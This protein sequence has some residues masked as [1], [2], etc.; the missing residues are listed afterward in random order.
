MRALQIS[1]PGQIAVVQKPNPRPGRD[2]LLLATQAAGL[3]QTDIELANGSM[4]YIREGRA[5]LPLTPGHE[6]VARVVGKGED[7]AGFEVGNLVVG[8]CSIG[9]GHCARCLSGNYHQ[10][11]DRHETGVLNLDGAMSG[12]FIFPARAAHRLI[13]DTPIEDAV[14]A[15]PA[16]VALRA[17]LRANW[18]GGESVLVV[19]AGT[20]GWL[21]AAIVMDLHGITVAVA[22][23]EAT[24]RVRA[25][26]L[27]CREGAPDEQF[28]I[29]FEASGNTAAVQHALEA[30][31]PSGRVIAVG[32]TGHHS[33][34]VDIDR[35]VVRDQ[36]VTGSLGSPGV[37]TQTLTML[38]KGRLRPSSLVTGRYSL[39]RAPDAYAALAAS[40]PGTGKLL[41]VP[42]EEDRL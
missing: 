25:I 13:P 21:I 10:C 26:E 38:G 20:I 14:F 33:H 34:P 23:P 32:L 8:E 19:G 42:S 17:V 37:W 1:G 29:V 4:V 5:H 18:Q 15:E 41:I 35:I 28:D 11:P 24:R 6:W 30:L 3:C 7:V 39:A 22:E 40:L 27:G 9:C 36:T 12:L 16:S 31:A 2:E